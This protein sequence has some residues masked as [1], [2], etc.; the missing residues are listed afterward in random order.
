M[1]HRSV[2]DRLGARYRFW[3]N[4]K[5]AETPSPQA[6]GVKEHTRNGHLDIFGRRSA[7]PH[8]SKRVTSEA[9]Q[10]LGDLPSSRREKSEAGEIFRELP[11]RQRRKSI[12]RRV[13]RRR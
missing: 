11:R 7:V 9:G 8:I 1:N 2:A 10:A 6:K 12:G 3:F 13:A 4:I 5:R